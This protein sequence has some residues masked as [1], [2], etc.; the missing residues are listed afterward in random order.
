MTSVKIVDHRDTSRFVRTSRALPRAVAQ[1]G[2][3]RTLPSTRQFLRWAKPCS[4][5]AR[6]AASAVFDS[7]CPRVRGR[8]PGGLVTGDHCGAGVGAAVV[9]PDEAQVGD[10]PETGR[11]QLGGELV[12]STGGDLRGPSGPGRR[13]PEQPAA[14]VGERDHEQA[15]AFALAGVVLP[16]LFAGAPAGADQR[17]VQQHHPATLA[18]DLFEGAVQARAA[19]R[20]TTSLTHR[21][22]VVRC[23]PLPPAR[24]PG[25]WSQRST[26]STRAAIRPGGRARHR[27]LIFFRWP[28]IRPASQFRVALDS[29]RRAV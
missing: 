1:V 14:I 18:G 25:R 8:F 7:F 6:T 12:V 26:A 3:V 16:V 28:R 11:Q 24:S 17:A 4:T 22:T 19:S 9:E 5:G 13:D 29:G 2:S 20:P 23:I 27:D 15:M 21:V 10:R